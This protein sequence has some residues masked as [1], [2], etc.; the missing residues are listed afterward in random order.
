MRQSVTNRQGKALSVR[1]EGPQDAA[2]IIFSNSLGTDKSMWDTQAEYLKDH[3]RVVRY[4]TRGHGQ[5]EVMGD[6]TLANLGEDVIDIMDALH[7]PQA[8]FCGISM[9]G[10][11]ALWLG[12]NAADRFKTITVANSAAKIGQMQAWLTR[13]EQV[14]QHGLADLVETTH[15]RWFS[16]D[17]DYQ[18]SA[19]AQQTIQSLATTPAKGYANACGVLAY[20]DVRA[21]LEQ[22][23]LPC[24]LICGSKD[25]VTTLE[26]GEFIRARAQNAETASIAASH[27]SNI[28]AAAEFNQVLLKFIER[29]ESPS[30]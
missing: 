25:L 14:E 1:V 2:V 23:A 19:L 8:H 22:L 6:S 4:D 10:I 11:T 20:A 24:L 16:N 9:G 18:H 5:S 21:E 15:S 13:A 7:I 29:N 17:F 26:D 28:E 3:Y 27:L 30:V 12:I